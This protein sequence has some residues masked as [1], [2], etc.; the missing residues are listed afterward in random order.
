[1][2]AEPLTEQCDITSILVRR[3]LR[4]PYGCVRG[5]PPLAT[6]R[7]MPATLVA[8]A[9]NPT[10]KAGVDVGVMR[11][12]NVGIV[13]DDL[14]A[15]VE[16]FVALGLNVVGRTE[17]GGDWVDRVVGLDG[18]RCDICVLRTADGDGGLELMRFHSPAA[19]GGDA[20]APPNTR[21]LRRLAFAVDDLDATIADARARG[22][23][24]LGDVVQY[25]DVYRLGYLRGPEGLILVLAERLG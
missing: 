14:D 3:R 1:M 8:S 24:L 5:W 4:R 18:V 7:A 20:A 15:T 2:A 16:F 10:R 6:T 22:A 19:V 12:E 13:V 9:R 23:T 11:L 25:E 17:V 21:G